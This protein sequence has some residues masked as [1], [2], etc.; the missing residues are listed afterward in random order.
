VVKNY[1][2]YFKLINI[3]PHR[4]IVRCLLLLKEWERFVRKCLSA[5][6]ERIKSQENEFSYRAAFSQFRALLLT[7]MKLLKV[8]N[9]I[10]INFNC[11]N[12]LKKDKKL[13]RTQMNFTKAKV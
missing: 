3:I 2:F 5:V 7:Y 13:Q 1:H 11:G 10:L 8:P 12:I 9:V 6:H 4:N